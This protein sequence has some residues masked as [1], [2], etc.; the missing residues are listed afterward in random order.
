M[1][2]FLFTLSLCNLI[3]LRY[4]VEIIIIEIKEEIEQ[5]KQNYNLHSIHF[6]MNYRRSIILEELKYKL[7]MNID[8]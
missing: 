2:Y 8:N 1:A 5:E 6:T 3:R 4:H 7:S